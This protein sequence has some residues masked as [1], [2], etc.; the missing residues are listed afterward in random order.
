MSTDEMDTGRRQFLTA[1]TTVIGGIGLGLAAVPFIGSWLPSSKAQALGAPIDVD[2]TKIELGQKLTIPW[3][4]QPIFVVH[5]TK[6]EVDEL[7]SLNDLLRDPLSKEPQQPNYI[8]ELYR[9]I[10]PEYVVLIGICT[11]LGC[12]PLY[13]PTP[14]S[15]Q[16]DWKGGFFCPC[17]GSLYDLAGRVYKG[18]PAPTNLVVPPYKFISDTVL[19]VGENPTG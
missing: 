7:A 6:Q 2:L 17:H 10:K 15:V 9:S 8:T 11:H 16:P 3:R 4:G 19:R 5:R 13:K 1:A 18:V 14:G 12:V